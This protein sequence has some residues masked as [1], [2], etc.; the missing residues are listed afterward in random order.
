LLTLAARASTKLGKPSNGRSERETG[1]APGNA[2]YALVV[3]FGERGGVAGLDANF[4]I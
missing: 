4:R 3:R 2:R 1:L